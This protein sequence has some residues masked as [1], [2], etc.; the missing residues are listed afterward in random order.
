MRFN[1]EKKV[2]YLCFIDAHSI[3]KKVMLAFVL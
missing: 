2:N 3:F 1:N